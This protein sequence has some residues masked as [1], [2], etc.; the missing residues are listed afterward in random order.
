METKYKIGD[1]ILLPDPDK[2]YLIE[3]I[4][5]N[6]K[7]PYGDYNSSIQFDMYNFICLENGHRYSGQISD[8]DASYTVMKVA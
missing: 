8:F 2:H 1:I 3:D 7:P 5:I 4:T 6:T